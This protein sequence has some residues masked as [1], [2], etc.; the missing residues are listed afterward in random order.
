MEN[1]QPSLFGQKH[2]SRDYTNPDC[3]GKNQFNSSFPASLVA[4]MYSKGLE[5]V[6]ICTDKH[7]TNGFNHL[8]RF[9]C[10]YFIYCYIDEIPQRLIRRPIF[11][12]CLRR[13]KT[14][15][16]VG[17]CFVGLTEKEM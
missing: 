9:F 11:V 13:I 6:Y 2:S 10:F 3:W 1:I 15:C 5:P 17:L 12:Y 8:V 7:N 16:F 14:N 4:Y